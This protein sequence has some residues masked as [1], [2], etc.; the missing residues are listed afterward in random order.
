[1]SFF[2]E[3]LLTDEL[4]D[5]GVLKLVVWALI[6]E[7]SPQNHSQFCTSELAMNLVVIARIA[8]S[9]ADDGNFRLKAHFE[10]RNAS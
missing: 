9:G 7:D 8:T 5:L 10:K 2:D 3:R 4:L 6:L 1:M